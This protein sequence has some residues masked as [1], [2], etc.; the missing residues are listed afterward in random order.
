MLSA[1][2]EWVDDW[3]LTEEVTFSAMQTRHVF[4]H[5]SEMWNAV[6]EITRCPGTQCHKADLEKEAAT[7]CVIKYD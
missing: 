3:Y 6:T 2:D 4:S 1:Y 5:L 7:L